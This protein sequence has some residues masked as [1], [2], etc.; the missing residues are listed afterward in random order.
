MS[1]ELEA[2]KTA[3]AAYK[4]EVST[5]VSNLLDQVTSLSA[6]VAELSANT[7]A[8]ELTALAADLQAQTEALHAK[9]TPAQ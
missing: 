1:A 5:D 6:K 8:T 3:L 7:D 9:V 4:A 2:V